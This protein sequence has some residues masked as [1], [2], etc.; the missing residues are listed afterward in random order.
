MK[1]DRE[2]LI[3]LMN[4]AHAKCDSINCIC[5]E[6]CEYDGASYCFEHLFIDHIISKGVTI[7]VRCGECKHW[8]A[9]GYDNL[10][11]ECL[12]PLGV[13]PAAYDDSIYTKSTDFCSYGERKEE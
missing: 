7:P 2:K 11:G 8:H 9:I 10:I 3:A 13:Y 5:G 4:E 6:E 12:K 1:T